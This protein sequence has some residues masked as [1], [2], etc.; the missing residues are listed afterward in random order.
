[1]T[2]TLLTL[3]L[4]SATALAFAALTG[5]AAQPRTAG[6]AAPEDRGTA[7]LAAAAPA[8]P[9]PSTAPADKTFV[10]P[11]ARLPKGFPPP[12]PVGQIMVKHY[13]AYRLARVE[14][15]DVPNPDNGD[16]ANAMFRPLFDHIQKNDIA[17]TAPVEMQYPAPRNCCG[18]ADE[19][20]KPYAIAF[21][22]AEPSIGK[23]GPA[24]IGP[25]IVDDVPA[26]TVV[27]IGVRG[28]YSPE[29]IRKAVEQLQ[30]W[31]DAHPDHLAAG[32]PRLLGYNSPL[33]PPF[34][35]YSEVQVPIAPPPAAAKATPVGPAS[36]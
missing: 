5:C 36:R 1:M 19:A 14:A 12:G 13:P 35:R 15:A 9:A 23:P 33:I 2:P 20:L 4:G 25:V 11:E 28:G 21:L 10:L 17:M 24:G 22:Y 18:G 30:A 34:M 16:P 32:A 31:L 27:S 26:Q 29:T 6:A 8:S 3:A 7:T